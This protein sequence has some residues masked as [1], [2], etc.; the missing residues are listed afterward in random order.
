[1][2]ER[3]KKIS[4]ENRDRREEVRGGKKSKK[5]KCL[6]TGAC[7]FSGSYMVDILLKSGYEVIATDREDAPRKW[8][9]PEAKFIPSDLTDKKTLE[10][11]MDSVEVIFHPAAVFNYSAPLDLLVKVN[12]YGTKNLL[13]VA[14]HRGVRKIVVWSTAGVYDVSK[15]EGIPIS[16]EGPIGPSNNYEYSKLKQE[17]LA[18]EYYAS[19]KIDVSIIRPAP[20]YGPRNLY[21]FANIVFGVAKTKLPILPIP[22]I[23]NKAVSVHVEDVCESALFLANSE[24]SSGQIYT[25]VDDSDYT[26]SEIVSIVG[27]LTDK[28]VMELPIVVNA[29]ALSFVFLQIARF[30]SLLR[31]YFPLILNNPYLEVLKYLEEDTARYIAHSFRFSNSK[32]KSTGYKLKYPDLKDGLPM[33]IKWYKEYGY[34]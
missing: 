18:M 12:V 17:E 19:G 5:F 3:K 15:S 23:N 33:T 4:P 27:K 34:L 25:I 20:I 6:V 22:R 10:G 7:G 11:V 1:M 24:V 26:F 2:Q 28:T 30:S 13:D 8:L 32:L 31:K 29:K 21:G 16:E 14:I 9:N